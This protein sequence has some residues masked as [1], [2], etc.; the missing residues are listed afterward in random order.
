MSH[1]SSC[2]RLHTFLGIGLFGLG[3]LMNANGQENQISPPNGGRQVEQIEKDF[4]VRIGVEEVRLDAVVLD[5]AGHQVSD[6][7]ADDFEIYQDDKP[8]KIISSTYISDYRAQPQ[9]KIISSRDSK[10]SSPIPAPPLTK[11]AVRRTIVFLIDDI[12]MSFPDLQKARMALLKFVEVQMQSGD[13]VA[14]MRTRGSNASFQSFSSDKRDLLARISKMQWSTE[15]R[16]ELVDGKPETVPIGISQILAVSF[17]I[18]TLQDMPGRKY[19]L[20]LSSQV[21]LPVSVWN[22]QAYN[23]IADAA[24]RAGIVIHT[25]DILGV[26]S[27]SVMAKNTESPSG[28]IITTYDRIDAETRSFEDTNGREFDTLTSGRTPGQKLLNQSND[29]KANRPLPLSQKTGGLFLSGNNFF[30]NG[31]GAVEEEMKGYY[32]L[33]YIPPANTF[34]SAN[35]AAYHKIK[36]R[37]KRPG[38]EIHTRDG[39]YNAPGTLSSPDQEAN[40]LLQAMFSPFRNNGLN[41]DLAAGYIDDPESGYLLRAWLHLNGQQVSF[42]NEKNGG[43]SVSLDVIAATSDINGSV[44]NSGNK[45]LGFRVNDDDKQWIR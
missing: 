4:N 30:L 24:L 39:F 43:N 44:R 34:Q 38:T 3:L 36:I 7:S 18:Q 9:P 31:I 19:L 25:L 5:K 8:Q 12:S 10:K 20:L 23:G 16:T 33:S 27:D 35:Q 11:D 32:L 21:I 42:I 6:L 2:I 45:H 14:F 22:D 28:K 1:Y 15:A 29:R 26:I 37:V 41:L 17:C 40:P 13:M